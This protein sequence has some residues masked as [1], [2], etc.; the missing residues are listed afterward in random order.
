MM[1][2]VEALLRREF[3]SA[4]QSEF[5]RWLQQLAARDGMPTV[6]RRK[7]LSF[8]PD[9]S[10]DPLF[11]GT[12]V[13][14]REPTPITDLALQP[15]QL[16]SDLPLSGEPAEDRAQGPAAKAASRRPRKIL[17]RIAVYPMV[18]A[19][20]L[21]AAAIAFHLL[22]PAVARKATTGTK[23]GAPPGKAAV[24]PPRDDQATW[25]MP[26]ADPQASVRS[27][28]RSSPM[29]IVRFVTRPKGAR[30]KSGSHALGSTP[31]QCAFPPGARA[32]F[33]FTKRGYVSVRRLFTVGTSDT[34]VAVDLDRRSKKRR[35]T[36]HR[37]HSGGPD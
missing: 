15:T 30:V 9:S 3:E 4:G 19:L 34:T 36:R 27:A 1:V 26:V 24:P 16:R 32:E 23:S 28:D 20:S 6:V 33:S 37:T 25:P 18:F 12:I 21:V 13:A 11:E 22:V 2:E 10:A 14:L 31:L 29:V 35:P 5:E 7:G 8:A 17:H